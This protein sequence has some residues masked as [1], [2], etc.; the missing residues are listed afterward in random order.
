MNTPVTN[1]LSIVFLPQNHDPADAFASAIA[2]KFP[3]ISIE[4]LVLSDKTLSDP[5]GTAVA[6]LFDNDFPQ[7]VAGEAWLSGWATNRG[8]V[9]VMPV[10]LDAASPVPPAPLNSIRSRLWPNDEREMLTTIGASL[11][12]AFRPGKQELFISYRQKDGTDI[13]HML[14]AHF[15]SVGFNTF[16]DVADDRFGDPNLEIGDDVQKE[17][18]ERLANASAMIHV[19]TPSSPESP[20]V[21]AEVESAI[22]KRIPILPLVFHDDS[23]KTQ[24]S[25][26]RDLQNLHRRVCILGGLSNGQFQLSGDHLPTIEEALVEYLLKVYQRRVLQPKLLQNAFQ[27]QQWDFSPVPNMA[28]LHKATQSASVSVPVSLLGCCSFEDYFFAPSCIEFVK[29][30][31]SLGQSGEA[32]ARSLYFYDGDPLHP[33]GIATVMDKEVQ[34]LKEANA[35]LV[36]YNEA[37]ARVINISEGFDAIFI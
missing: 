21:H 15:K 11:G 30:I 10:A 12:M 26:F 16:L 19:D 18:M 20:W 36:H 4:T 6:F 9:P 33:K 8:S 28:H 24:P 13:A 27:S 5:T 23:V 17:I 1:R 25:R 7:D 32:F 29:D 34:G 22:G 3:G 14:D 31:S 35:E 2:S 37:I